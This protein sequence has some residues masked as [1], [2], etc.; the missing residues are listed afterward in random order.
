VA[1]Y[2]LIN[3]NKVQ[4]GV[5]SLKRLNYGRH[6][7]AFILLFLAKASANGAMLLNIMDQQLP[8]NNTD[9]PAIYRA[10]N[11]LEKSGAVKSDWDTSGPGVAKKWYTITNEGLEQ[12]KQFKVHIEDRKR[13][14]DFFLSECESL[15][16]DERVVE[17]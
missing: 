9:G 11:E 17:K 7:P 3:N 14:L 6:L 13:N 16:L 8:S 2:N 4:K 10:L 1:Q 5:V 12:L 15:N